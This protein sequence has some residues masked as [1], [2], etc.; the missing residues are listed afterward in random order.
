MSAVGYMKQSLAFIHG[1]YRQA[2]EGLS[3]EQLHFVPE[4]ESHS[5][6]WIIWHGA[7]VEDLIV[8]QVIKGEPQEWD[9]AGWAERTGLPAK[10]FGTGQ[11]TDDA[12]AVRIDNYDEFARY[13]ARVAAL[14]QTYLSSLSDDDLERELTVG[15]RTES[16]GQAVTL[17]LVTHLNGHR[18]EINLLRGMMGFPPV[19]PNQGG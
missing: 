12:R 1:S 17:H 5:I 7:R 10:G 18:G 9:A 16:V 3:P 2:A 11:S 8:Q 4:G 13:A 15:Q 19:M 14:T 6:A